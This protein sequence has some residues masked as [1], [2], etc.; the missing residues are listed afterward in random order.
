MPTLNHYKRDSQHV[1][2]IEPHPNHNDAM[3]FFQTDNVEFQD[4]LVS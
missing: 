2:R 3:G 4:Y 1:S